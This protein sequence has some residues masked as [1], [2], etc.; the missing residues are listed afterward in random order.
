LVYF[1][2]DS[3]LS[4]FNPIRFNSNFSLK[5]ENPFSPILRKSWFYKYNNRPARSGYSDRISR[6]DPDP[7]TGQPRVGSGRP[8]V[9]AMS[10]MDTSQARWKDI[11]GGS[12]TNSAV[13]YSEPEECKKPQFEIQNHQL[14]RRELRHR[15][16]PTDQIFLCS[17]REF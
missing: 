11:A 3:V 5:F 14:S 13:Y 8:R 6:S 4:P 12:P 10:R 1:N 9:L 16:I 15:Y 17:K 2:F 7:I